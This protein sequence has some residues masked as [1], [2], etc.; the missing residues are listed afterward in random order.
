MADDYIKNRETELVLPPGVYAYVLDQTKGPVSVCCGPYKTSL[1]NTDMMVTY[2]PDSKKFIPAHSQHA[3]IQVSIS[4]AKG[5]YVVLHNPPENGRQPEP[6]KNES[7][8]VNGLMMGQTQ[9]HPG[10]W[11]HP[12]WPG[13]FA[14]VIEGHQLRSNQYLIVK[15]V[16]DEAAKANWDK[17]VIK[18]ATPNGEQATSGFNVKKDNLVTGQLIIIKGT[19][20]SFY[21]PPTG[22]RVLEDRDGS[23]VRDAVTLERLEYAILLDESGNKE[24]VKGPDVVFPTPTQEFVTKKDNNGTIQRKFRAY[25]LQPTNGIYIK[26]IADYKDDDGDQ[27]T[28]GDE[29]FIT[30][31]DMPIYYPR[32]EHAIIKYGNQD[33]TYAVAIPSGEGRYV[34]NRNTGVIRLVTGPAMFLPNPINEVIVRRVLSVTECEQYYPGNRVALQVN[35]ALRSTQ[36]ETNGIVETSRGIMDSHLAGA[37]SKAT[38]TAFAD[39]LE[40]GTVYTPPRTITLDTKYDGAVNIGVWSGYAVQIVNSKGERRTVIG[41]KSVLLE[42]D[43]H[44]EK[45]SLSTGKPK[46]DERRINTPY[47][48]YISNPVS[49]VISLKTHDLVNVNVHLKYLVRFEE[50]DQKIWFSVDNYIQYMVDHMRSLIGN[51]VR[52]ISV[53]DFYKDAAS[54]LRDLILGAKTGTEPRQLKHFKENGMT[55]YDVEVITVS[56]Q[57]ANIADMLSSSRQKTL[58]EQIELDRATVRL[59]IVKGIQTAKRQEEEQIHETD[60]LKI[61]L[62]NELESVR[63][64]NEKKTEE[65]RGEFNKIRKDNERASAEM[66]VIISELLL[67]MEDD[68]KK[69]EQKFKDIDADRQ[70]KLE[71]AM[72]TAQ[73]TRMEAIGPRLIEA[74]TAM[75]QTGQL[76]AIAEHLAPLSIVRNQSLSGTLEQLVAGTPLEGMLNNVANMSIRNVDE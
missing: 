34:L 43:E 12:L 8:P 38:T 18:S 44:L 35:D 65:S 13:Q 63:L 2:D 27:K 24:Y 59:S 1:S 49:D 71:S 33:K 28:A 45:M 3:A 25:E 23:Y 53:Q 30:G 10:P 41:P 57:D 73:K 56:V 22:V 39:Q 7:L 4:A 17:S 40:R 68:K 61:R 76:Q 67:A 19:E 66:S 48:R 60:L 15:V 36:T 31:E 50:T 64:Q 5:Y 11:N 14:T 47:L 74:M 9:N 54:I 58:S 69:L 26:V 16:D 52:N 75:A 70:I 42:Y 46:S 29:M 62:S 20:V 32:E 6:G 37:I 72:A 21:I 51:A 55:I